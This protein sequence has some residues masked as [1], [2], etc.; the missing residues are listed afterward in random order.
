MST[1][2]HLPQWPQA[3]ERE[4]EL[5]RNV[6]ESGQWGGFHPYV[7]EFEDSFAAFQHCGFGVATFNGTVSLELALTVLGIGAGD[8]V[9]VPAISFIS[10]ATSI[11]RVGAVPVFV[12]IEADS[13]NID[14]H[15]IREAISSKTKAVMAVHFGGMPC[16]IEEMGA[17]CRDHRLTLLEDAA[18]A[19]GS[20]WNDK[21]AGSF[22]VAGSFS[23]QNGKVLTA[24][25]GGIL[26]TSD[27]DLAEQARSIANCGRIP[28]RSFYEHHNLGTNF[29]MSAFQA[30]VLLAQLER[31]PK[32]IELRTANARLLKGLLADVQQLGWQS[33]PE[34]VTR[35][36]WYLLLARV[37]EPGLRD[38]LCQA[39][40]A[41]G[42]PNGFYPHTL[43]QNPV[44][45]SAP[46]RVRPCPVAEETIRDS[47]WLPHRVLLAEEEAVRQIADLLRS[48]VEGAT[49]AV[50]ASSGPSTYREPSRPRTEDAGR[51]L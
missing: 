14:P 17:I 24:G 29:R 37:R 12:D 48:V 11:S 4:A 51:V 10:S 2:I 23:F 28:G 13:F 20:E 36:S 42:V 30:A 6:L 47:F 38:R 9:I 18:H 45:E 25:E 34:E 27:A 3:D 21:R 43:Y 15:R 41:A 35:S 39:L 1:A 8:E 7:K 19:Q 40:T 32:Q 49:R 16:Q 5:L 46:C 44:Y 50:S 26:L 33:Q 31:L 22:G